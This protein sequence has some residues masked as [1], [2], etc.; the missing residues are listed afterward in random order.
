[1]WCPLQE[2][3]PSTAA[4]NADNAAEMNKRSAGAEDDIIVL[5]LMKTC[6]DHLWI[7]VQNNN[8]PK[9]NANLSG[10]VSCDYWRQKREIILGLFLI[11]NTEKLY[12]KY[13]VRNT[14]KVCQIQYTKQEAQL[15]PGDRETRKHAKNS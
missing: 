9:P 4:D 10:S 2:T 12:R 11:Q 1:M 6:F 8:K 14:S 7:F 15:L 13:K 3:V 5:Y